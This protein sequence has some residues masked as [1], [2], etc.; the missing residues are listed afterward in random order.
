MP[1]LQHELYVRQ[2]DLWLRMRHCQAG[3]AGSDSAKS[4]PT[5]M[6]GWHLPRGAAPHSAYFFYSLR[7]LLLLLL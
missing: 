1:W 3:Q 4:V 7:L 5:I 6:A 2:F